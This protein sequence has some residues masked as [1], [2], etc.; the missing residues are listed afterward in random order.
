[1]TST[2]AGLVPTKL[3]K[4]YLD[5]RLPALCAAAGWPVRAALRPGRAAT[6]QT[7]RSAVADWSRAGRTA[8]CPWRRSPRRPRRAAECG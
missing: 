5:C 8:R 2:A 4:V 7:W 6:A 3:A 1:L